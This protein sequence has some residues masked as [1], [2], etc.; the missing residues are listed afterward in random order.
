MTA[1]AAKMLLLAGP[2]V[3][4]EFVA[5]LGADR[6]QAHSDPYEA[7][8]AL[9]GRPWPVVVLSAGQDDF[10]SLCRACR[11]LQRDTFLLALGPPA[12]EPD[13]RDLA[14]ETLDDYLV[15]PLGRRD[16]L[17]LES[18]LQAGLSQALAHADP[19]DTPAPGETA[20]L[21]ASMQTLTGLEAAAADLV[22]QRLATNVRWLDTA[23]LP[24]DQHAL[25]TYELDTPR[26]LCSA[27][28]ARSGSAAWLAG[29]QALLGPLALAARRTESLRRLAITDHLTG[30]YN[31][32]YFYHV[33]DQILQ[34]AARQGLLVTLLLYDID[35]FKR[36][37]DTYGHAVGDEIL[38]QTAALMKRIT[39]TQD[40]VARIGGDEFAVLFWDT[41]GP[42]SA[43]SS[44]PST[45]YA[46]ADRFR[47]AVETQAFP[48]LGPVA[49]GVLSISGGLATFPHEGQSCRELLSQADRALR[50]AKS[51]GKN[52]IYLVG[53]AL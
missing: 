53:Q 21:I 35:D 17:T 10:P 38:R 14:G 29:V 50:A 15:A 49:R 36:Y 8:D 39:R 31:R 18:R 7:M 25:L 4:A 40:I 45:A 26:T 46:L 51:A 48:S 16:W 20:R 33:T 28:P 6:V 12:D 3:G 42:R 19:A 27:A 5:R 32:R 24:P 47:K 43:A 44:P 23:A 52:Q 34:H 30:A 41:A 13:M 9:A 2:S 11:R 22:G 1:A 37:N